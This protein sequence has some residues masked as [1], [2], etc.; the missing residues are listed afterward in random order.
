MADFTDKKF[1]KF[2]L[3]DKK[4]RSHLDAVHAYP[5]Q[6]DEFTRE[7]VEGVIDKINC[8]GIIAIVSR[9]RADL[10]R[11]RDNQNK[12]AIDEYRATLK[13]MLEHIGILDE[14]GKLVKPY[15]HLAIHGMKDEWNQ[16]VEIGTLRR[17]SCAAEV[18]EWLVKEFAKHIERYKVD[19]QFPGDPSKLVHRYGD[20][21][22]DLNYLGYGANFNIVQIEISRTLR[23]KRQKLLVDIFSDLVIGFNEKF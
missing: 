9:T 18:R 20:Q 16:D 4:I 22:S 6:A 12:D 2:H 8:S 21:T 5:P 10:N 15:L 23:E 13:F 3:G 19:N 11:P 1:I 17:Q 14:N 7:I